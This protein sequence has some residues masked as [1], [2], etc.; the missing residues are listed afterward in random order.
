MT[1]SD[2]IPEI[3]EVFRQLFETE[4]SLEESQ[5]FPTTVEDIID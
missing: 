1:T 3:H 2:M 5:T 4:K